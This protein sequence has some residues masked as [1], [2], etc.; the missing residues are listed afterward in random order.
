[1]WYQNNQEDLGQET[2]EER[3]RMVS[4]NMNLLDRE[5]DDVATNNKEQRKQR[6]FEKTADK[7]IWCYRFCPRLMYPLARD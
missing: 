6:S 7:F 2:M 4:C 1:M 3:V 5:E